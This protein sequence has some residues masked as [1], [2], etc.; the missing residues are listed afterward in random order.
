MDLNTMRSRKDDLKKR[1]RPLNMA[2][3]DK[4]PTAPNHS[5]FVTKRSNGNDSNRSIM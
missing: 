4:A 5:T 1:Y 2:L 3:Q